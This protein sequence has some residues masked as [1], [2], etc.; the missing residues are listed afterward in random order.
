MLAL[1]S[2]RL[3]FFSPATFI[4]QQI[5]MPG[6]L[7]SIHYRR[8]LKI[9]FARLARNLSPYDYGWTTFLLH[10][11]GQGCNMRATVKQST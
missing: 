2:A 10:V 4:H 11:A 9:K 7:R 6:K 1:L 8:I 3:Y 5:T